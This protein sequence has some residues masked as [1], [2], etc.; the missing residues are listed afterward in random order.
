MYFKRPVVHVLVVLFLSEPVA[1]QKSFEE[2][3]VLPPGGGD[4]NR[5]LA[6]SSNGAAGRC[7]LITP[8]G[9]VAGRRGELRGGRLP[10]ESVGL[11]GRKNEINRLGDQVA[12]LNSD[13]SEQQSALA[14]METRRSSAHSTA[15]TL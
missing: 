2:I 11:I 1:G 9:F 10:Q 15:D 13:L 14:H 7:T 3:G 8:D 5:P 12:Q 6:I 4:Y